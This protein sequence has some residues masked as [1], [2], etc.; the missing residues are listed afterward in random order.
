ME[1]WSGTLRV[2]TAPAP[3]PYQMRSG[4][5]PPTDGLGGHAEEP[6]ET[7]HAVVRAITLTRGDHEEQDGLQEDASSAEQDG[8]RENPM[9]TTAAVGAGKSGRE[10]PE[11]LAARHS[12]AGRVCRGDAT[13]R[14]VGVEH[15]HPFLAP[16]ERRSGSLT[17]LVQGTRPC[18]TPPRRRVPCF[19]WGRSTRCFAPWSLG[20]GSRR[21]VDS[22]FR[23]RFRAPPEARPRCFPEGDV[24]STRV[25]RVRGA[26]RARGCG[27]G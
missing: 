23:P 12:V 2:R 25:R 16:S 8:L 24:V 6:T 5:H 11:T 13:R 4:P 9:S 1:T 14:L 21:R 10:D 7:G 3:L 26:R 18:S 17:P 27:R 20:P 22:G 19:S 15:G